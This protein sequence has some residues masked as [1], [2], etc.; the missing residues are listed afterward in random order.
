MNKNLFLTLSLI[1]AINYANSLSACAPNPN[2]PNAA[3]CKSIQLSPSSSLAKLIQA[4]TICL[5]Y[6]CATTGE[7]CAGENCAT[8]GS[9]TYAGN[10]IAASCYGKDCSAANLGATQNDKGT[11]NA[12]SSSNDV[13]SG[14]IALAYDNGIQLSA[15]TVQDKVLKAYVKVRS[16]LKTLIS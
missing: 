14:I 5:G 12:I 1:L 13:G 2:Y 6:N 16:Y 7:P 3:K 4:N 11:T 10:S 8:G 9:V 15:N